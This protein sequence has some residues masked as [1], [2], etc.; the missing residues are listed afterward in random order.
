VTHIPNTLDL[1]SQKAHSY[2]KNSNS[3]INVKDMPSLLPK[4]Y[5]GRKLKH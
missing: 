5:R 2:F 1:E 4:Y 3:Y